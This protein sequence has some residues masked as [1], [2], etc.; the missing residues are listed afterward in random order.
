GM[1]MPPLMRELAV[2]VTRLAFS[3]RTPQARHKLLIAP[4]DRDLKHGCLVMRD[5]SVVSLSRCALTRHR[6]QRRREDCRFLPDLARKRLD[7]R[8]GLSS[9]VT[10]ECR[11]EDKLVLEFTDETQWPT[12]F[13][14]MRADAAGQPAT[15]AA[16]GFDQA[17]QGRTLRL[18]PSTPEA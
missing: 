1:R 13:V 8:P 10:A 4:D 6:L 5:L 9:G 15:P 11:V 7:R 3:A 12:D 2:L 17:R 18:W 16:L 14:S